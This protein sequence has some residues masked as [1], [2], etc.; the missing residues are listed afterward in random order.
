[1]KLFFACTL[2]VADL[3]QT[4]DIC[5]HGMEMNPIIGQCGERTDPTHYFLACIAA[6]VMSTVLLPRW[7]SSAIVSSVLVAQVYIVAHNWAGGYSPL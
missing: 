6:L 7:L 4:V 3:R 2:L 5:Q 1:M